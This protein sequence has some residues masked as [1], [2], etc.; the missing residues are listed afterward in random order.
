MTILEENLKR[1]KE[2]LDQIEKTYFSEDRSM[3]RSIP[4]SSV[5]KIA[6]LENLVRFYQNSIHT[7][8]LESHYHYAQDIKTDSEN[9][10][11][12]DKQ[13]EL[14][15]KYGETSIATKEQIEALFV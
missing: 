3:V 4:N 5:K 14:I 8:A 12:T 1:K 9:R 6:T 15:N 7:F 2:L 10:F 13:I 11:V